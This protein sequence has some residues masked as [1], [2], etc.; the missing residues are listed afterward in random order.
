[1]GQQ[2]ATANGPQ[3]TQSVT[4]CSPCVI[5]GLTPSVLAQFSTKVL[6]SR[7]QSATFP[8]SGAPSSIEAGTTF[9]F[10]LSAAG[11]TPASWSGLTLLDTGTPIIG[12]FQANG[13][14]NYQ[15]NPPLINAGTTVSIAGA[16]NGA[17]VSN[18]TT[19][20]PGAGNNTTYTAVVNPS[21]TNNNQVVG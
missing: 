9:N 18:I 21:T 12:A 13:V 16:V 7:T 3:G 17:A 6:W 14:A 1:N 10:A 15:T 8:N 11:K 19:L 5:V 2:V 20:S 4:S